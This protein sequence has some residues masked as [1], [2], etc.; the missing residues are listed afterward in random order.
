MSLRGVAA[1]VGFAER[2]PQRFTEDETNLDLLSGV[3]V[4]AMADAGFA[5]SEVD[6]LLVHPIGGLPGF[7]PA[8]V[9]EFIGL[10]PRFAELVDLGGATGAGM[11]WRAAAAIGAGM[12]T[13]CLCLTGT[14]RRPRPPTCSRAGSPATDSPSTS[15]YPWSRASFACSPAGAYGG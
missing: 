6:G 11:I 4:E 5:R 9:A 8:T 12:C 7:V 2:A 14:R 3:A 15:W 13:T 1:V 10:R